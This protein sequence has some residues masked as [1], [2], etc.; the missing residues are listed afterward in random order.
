MNSLSNNMLSYLTSFLNS[1][2]V[3]ALSAINQSFREKVLIIAFKN[4]FGIINEN[5]PEQPAKLTLAHIISWAGMQPDSSI[6]KNIYTK[7]RFERWKIKLIDGHHLREIYNKSLLLL[8][9]TQPN[10]IVQ[11]HNQLKV[12]W[13]LDRQVKDY[14]SFIL[15][16]PSQTDVIELG[17]K[18]EDRST[19]IFAKIGT[20]KFQEVDYDIAAFHHLSD[21]RS[22]RGMLNQPSCPFHSLNLG[23]TYI[24]I[25][26]KNIPHGTR[27]YDFSLCNLEV[28]IARPK[29]TDSNPI[30]EEDLLQKDLISE[31]DPSF[32]VLSRPHLLLGSDLKYID[33][34]F[35]SVDTTRLFDRNLT[36]IM[37]EIALQNGAINIYVTSS[38]LSKTAILAAKIGRAHV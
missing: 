36:Q 28:S 2:D 20:F 13:H 32:P 14:N 33:A 16:D 25:F 30:K 34:C 15:K 24:A 29:V 4:I 31:K 3:I 10:S 17:V 27:S 19:E 21:E 26:R 37:M 8:E 11:L 1:A 9:K 6:H 38:S 18:L 7:Q 22:I 12:F 5:L 23:K 35:H